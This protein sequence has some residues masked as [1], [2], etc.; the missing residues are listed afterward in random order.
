MLV[1]RIALGQIDMQCATKAEA[2]D[3]YIDNNGACDVDAEDGSIAFDDGRHRLQEVF[4]ALR[5]GVLHRS[6][7]RGVHFRPHAARLLLPHRAL[8]VS[9]DAFDVHRVAH[10]RDLSCASLG[11]VGARGGRDGRRLIEP[12]PPPS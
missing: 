10:V 11:E 2:T 3:R 8:V 4:Q 7:G 5:V 6:G 9:P 12:T 1:A